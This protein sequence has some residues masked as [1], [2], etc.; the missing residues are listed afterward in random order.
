MGE[1]KDFLEKL[2]PPDCRGDGDDKLPEGPEGLEKTH[3]K[4]LYV[5]TIFFKK[6]KN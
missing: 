2:K 5:V 3:G 4:S 1:G 6:V